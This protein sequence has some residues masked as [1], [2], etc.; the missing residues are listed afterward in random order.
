LDAPE[1]DVGKMFGTVTGA[2]LEALLKRL[3]NA[4]PETPERGGSYGPFI[5][6]LRDLAGF[7]ERPASGRH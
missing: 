5:R 3:G 1:P 4:A 2:S 7:E 6:L